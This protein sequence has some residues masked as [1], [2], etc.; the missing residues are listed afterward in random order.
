[1]EQFFCIYG[2]LRAA[3]LEKELSK[4]TKFTIA[5]EGKK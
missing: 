1:M 5:N 2:L 3:K 4:E